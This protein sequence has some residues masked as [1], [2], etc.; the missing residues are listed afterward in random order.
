MISTNRVTASCLLP[1][2][3]RFLNPVSA[4]R[5]AGILVEH[6]SKG[7]SMSDVTEQ[8]RQE[9]SQ[10]GVQLSEK[11]LNQWLDKVVCQQQ[12]SGAAIQGSDFP[13]SY[14]TLQTTLAA[15]IEM[16]IA[17][18]EKEGLS[19][20]VV[21][22]WRSF[23]RQNELFEISPKV[24]SARGGESFHNYG[25]AVDLAFVTPEGQISFD[26]SHNWK[27]LGEIGKNQGLVWGGDFETLV[28][29]GHFEYHP[30]LSLD[31]LQK[32]FNQR[33]IAAVWQ[34]VP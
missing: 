15:K 12:I 34:A 14:Q 26:E 24:T 4:E 21:E 20:R 30:D 33:G 31:D 5:V 11:S 29:R 10:Q 1:S 18:A 6:F 17:Q 32:I 22:G 25:L 9:L 13:K 27:R 28:D 2:L 19:V 16:V 8:I 23:E 3:Q 7:R